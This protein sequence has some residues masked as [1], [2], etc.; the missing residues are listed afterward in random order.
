MVVGTVAAIGLT[1]LLQKLL[2]Q[3]SPTDPITFAAVAALVGALTLVPCYLPA[4]R[5]TRIE[6]TKA[7]RFD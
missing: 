1:R 3:I 6:P 4:R 2:F 7:L 5:A